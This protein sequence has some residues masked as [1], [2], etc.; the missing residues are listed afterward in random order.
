METTKKFE[1]MMT[2]GKA[3]ADDKNEISLWNTKPIKKM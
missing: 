1:Q 2:K 3:K